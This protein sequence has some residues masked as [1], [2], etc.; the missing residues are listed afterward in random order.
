MISMIFRIT[1]TK[2]RNPSSQS[3]KTAR[4]RVDLSLKFDLCEETWI[5][6][7][8]EDLTEIEYLGNVVAL[9]YHFV[10]M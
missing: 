3:G 2:G 9:T 6:D 10:S 8:E 1:E 5:D 7:I 4:L